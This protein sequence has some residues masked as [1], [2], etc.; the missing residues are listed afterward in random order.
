M[1][2]G[3]QVKYP[4]FLS[5]SLDRFSKTPQIPN[6]MKIRPVGAE[7]FCAHGRT[8]RR[9]DLTKLIVAFR[10]FANAPF[11]IKHEIYARLQS[12][13]KGW[14]RSINDKDLKFFVLYVSRMLSSGIWYHVVRCVS[15]YV[16][17]TPSYKTTRCHI[18]L[19]AT[20]SSIIND[21]A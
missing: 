1:Y 15:N 2:I 16:S 17:Q 13:E 21:H 9:T 20:R 6:F 5:D 3:L 11:K 4:L 19:E 10:N 14:R 18:Y 12:S 8:D 7:L